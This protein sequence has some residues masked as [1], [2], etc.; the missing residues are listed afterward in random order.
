MYD[1]WRRPVDDGWR[2]LMEDVRKGPEDDERRR[3]TMYNGW[4]RPTDD[5]WKQ[6]MQDVRKGP[7]DDEKRRSTMYDGWRRPVDDGWRQLM[8]DVR[9]GPEDDEQRRSTMYD[10]W[11]RPMDDGWKQLMEDVRKVPEDDERRRSTVYDGWRQPV[12]DVWKQLME[13][14]RKGP[15]DDG[16]K[17]P[18]D[19]G[20]NKLEEAVRRRP[21]KG[22]KDR[23]LRRGKTAPVPPRGRSP[24][25]MDRK[26]HQRTHSCDSFHS[27]DSGDVAPPLVV[28]PPTRGIALSSPS[29]P[30]FQT[31]DPCNLNREV[32]HDKDWVRMVESLLAI[33]EP[34]ERS[35]HVT[36]RKPMIG[37]TRTFGDPEDPLEMLTNEMP[38]SMDDNPSNPRQIL[39]PRRT[40]ATQPTR[41]SDEKWAAMVESVLACIEDDT[42][43]SPDAR[44]ES[45]RRF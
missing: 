12:D 17:G 38:L 32:D 10:G 42:F 28:G 19:D 21:G 40:T 6:L 24:A 7:E 18:V 39:E 11:R 45:D 23:T 5:G 35:D 22:N 27:A 2:Q 33:P 20:R 14:V 30:E 15:E 25:S 34:P 26:P 9:K 8:E 44:E 1:G 41:S 16:Q 4:R 29:E 36:G 3:S 37:R 31:K 43:H 13:D